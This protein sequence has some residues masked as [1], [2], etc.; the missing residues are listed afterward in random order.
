MNILAATCCGIVFTALLSMTTQA[1]EKDERLKQSHEVVLDYLTSLDGVRIGKRIKLEDLQSECL[2]KTFDRC[3]FLLLRYPR[4]PIEVVPAA[5]LQVNNL[6]IVCDGKVTRISN[7][8]ELR[9]FFLQKFPMSADAEVMADG[10]RCWLFLAQEL[11]QDGFVKFGNPSI[12]TADSLA[13]G[14]VDVTKDSGDGRLSVTMEFTK[15]KLSKVSSGG[16]VVPGAR[17]LR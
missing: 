10:V 1:D 9:D 3:D 8:I 13:E 17:R 4:Y 12:K 7:E 11:H 5:P 2:R 15:G 6:F 16:N 14:V